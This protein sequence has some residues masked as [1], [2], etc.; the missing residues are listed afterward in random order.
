VEDGRETSGEVK[1]IA[2]TKQ[3]I[4]SFLS[5]PFLS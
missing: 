4:S 5:F 2:E 1:E 3:V